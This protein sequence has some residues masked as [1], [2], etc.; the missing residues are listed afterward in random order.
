MNKIDKYIIKRFLSTFFYALI[1]LLTVVIVVDISEKIDDFIEH[2]LSFLTIITEYYIHFIPYFANLFSPLFIFISVVFF[3]SK[4]ADHSEIIAIYNSGMSFKRFLRPF[5]IAS[6]L[7]ACLSFTLGNFI[8][9]PSNKH[10]IDFENKYFRNSQKIF[11]KNIHIQ[12]SENE[13]IYL[14]GYNSRKKIGYKFSLEK[15][16]GSRLSSKLRANYIEWNEEKELWRLNKYEIREFLAENEK[17]TIGDKIDS[18]INLHP[19]DFI[20]KSNLAESMNLY[21]LNKNIKQKDNI[22]SGRS[23]FY[24]LEKHKRIAFPFASIILTL[25]AVSVS[26]RKSKEGIGVNLGVGLLISF[27]YILLFQFSSTLSIN[28]NLDPMTSV[29]IPNILYM[30]LS[31]I[32]LRKHQMN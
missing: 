10:K 15:F 12:T 9:P 5:M 21:E 3:T 8:I 30:V 1:L 6:I 32:L 24:K 11:K 16:K 26:A 19:D 25:I 14:E 29:W 22:T 23:K 13:Y 20:I 28:G 27:S 17:F 7:L 18:T 4:M 31:I 2:D